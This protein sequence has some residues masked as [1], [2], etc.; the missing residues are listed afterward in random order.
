M[1]H[2]NMLDL[3]VSTDPRNKESLVDVLSVVQIINKY[4]S[5]L[6]KIS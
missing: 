6:P 4:Y 2:T 5:P 3:S 1:K